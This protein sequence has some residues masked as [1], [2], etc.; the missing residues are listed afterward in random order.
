VRGWGDPAGDSDSQVDERTCFEVVQ[1]QGLE[2]DP[3]PTNDPVRRT[4]AV[5]GR[6]S[7]LTFNGQPGL[8]IDPRCKVLRKGFMGGYCRQRVKVSGDDRF[9]DKPMK[10]SFSHVHDGLQYLLVGEGEDDR[11]IRGAHQ[12]KKAR[13][14]FTTKRAVKGW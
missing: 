5:R 10:N 7:T 9:H 3:A 11:A 4:E 13:V 8:I 6:L 14:R 1:A 2:I 12:P